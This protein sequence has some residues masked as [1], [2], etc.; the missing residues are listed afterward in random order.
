MSL[1]QAIAK[2]IAGTEGDL[3][4][5]ESRWTRAFKM[6]GKV[7]KVTGVVASFVGAIATGIQ[8]YR[9]IKNGAP[10]SVI[11][12]ETIEVCSRSLS[13]CFIVS[14]VFIRTYCLRHAGYRAEHHENI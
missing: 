11:A 10:P 13:Y 6:V 4:I 2:T 8:L 7:A 12:L 3:V 14:N 5:I 9:D 1:E